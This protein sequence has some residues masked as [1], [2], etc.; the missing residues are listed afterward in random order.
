MKTITV[1]GMP[2]E[3]NDQ[4]EAVIRKLEGQLDA[5]DGA[6]GQADADVARLTTELSTKDAELVTAKAQLDAAKLSPQQLRDAAKVYQATVD[7]A[8]VLGVKVADDMDEAAIVRAVVT[9]RVGDACKEWN[10]LQ[11][12]AS[13][14]SLAVDA[15]PIDPMR[16]ALSNGSVVIS[17]TS[18]IRDG[19]RASRYAN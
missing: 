1:D 15:K 17:D 14:A 7:K 13:F 5:I 10:D 4:A 8:K 16:Q 19:A 11:F 18:S 12:A 6:K 3:V 2:I 9:A